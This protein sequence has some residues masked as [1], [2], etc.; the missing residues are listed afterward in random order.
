MVVIVTDLDSFPVEVN[1]SSTVKDLSEQVQDVIGI[2]AEE[3][4][5]LLD[6]RPL[7]PT[8]KL[9]SYESQGLNQDSLLVI[10]KNPTGQASSS[11]AAGQRGGQSQAGAG[12]ESEEQFAEQLRQQVLS[13]SHMRE[14]VKQ[15]SPDLHAALESPAEFL[16]QLRR[17]RQ[18]AD[19]AARRQQQAEMELAA[20]DEFDVEAQ[21]KIEEAIRQQQVYENLESAMENMPEAFG[22]VNMLY[23]QAEINGTPLKAFVDSGAQMTIMSPECAEKCGIKRLLDTR[24]SGIA[25]GVGTAKIL[26]RIHSAQMKLEDLYLPVSL[27]VIEGKDVDLLF[28]L[29]MLKR[30]QASIDLGQNALIINGRKIRFLDEHELP[31]NARLFAEEQESEASAAGRSVDGTS[32]SAPGTRP[33][34]PQFPG[35]GA[36][37]GSQPVSGVG[38]SSA[39][40]GSTN[41][42]SSTQA[43]ASSASAPSATPAS[44]NAGAKWPAESI[45][46]LKD[47]GA[48][49][50]QAVALLDAAGGN[51]DAAASFLFQ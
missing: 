41:A 49:D 1:L 30:Y 32:A 15:T 22:S 48:T 51:V 12:G 46:A 35:S 14:Q 23:V 42:L 20:A 9:N 44:G 33:T 28:G 3:Q 13:N 47:L 2:P 5:V 17:E 4:A 8:K 26:G 7:D 43:A 37:L 38:L 16:R 10:G 29:D 45:Q 50:Q 19:E 11:G 6:G 31:K 18:K 34:P 25:R 36:T 40:S 21:A 24:F 27:T 39:T